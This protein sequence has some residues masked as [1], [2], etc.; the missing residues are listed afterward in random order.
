MSHFAR[1]AIDVADNSVLVSAVSAFEI[2]TKH[3]IG[4]LPEG[5]QLASSFDAL[6]EGQGFERL[7]ITT[8][9]GARAGSLPLHHR[10]PFDRILIAQA[11]G[12]DFTIVSNE[13][14]FD[15]YGV[16]RLW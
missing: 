9:D 13:K 6:V 15:E 8:A 14:L 3:G 2:A 12:G 11:L 4:K 16:N 1:R 7:P 10:D 5:A